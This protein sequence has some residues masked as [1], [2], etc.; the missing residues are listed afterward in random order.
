MNAIKG[1]IWEDL[2]LMSQAKLF[3]GSWSQVSQLAAICVVA[4]GG[5]AVLPSTTQVGTKV[6]WEIPSVNFYEPLF[7]E[8]GHWIY[9]DSFDLDKDAHKSYKK[10]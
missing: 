3:I 9:S 1:D 2:Y 10:A 7:L 4:N 6:R 8:K 5:F